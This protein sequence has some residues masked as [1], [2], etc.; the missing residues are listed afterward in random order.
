MPLATFAVGLTVALLVIAKASRDALFLSTYDVKQ[1]P[2]L[3]AVAAGLSLAA[4]LFAGR[5]FV[6]RSPARVLPGLFVLNALVHAVEVALIPSMPAVASVL[7]FLHLA[8]FG[9]TTMAG[10]WAVVN[11]SFDPHRAKRAVAQIALGGPVGGVAGGVLGLGLAQLGGVRI[12]LSLLVLLSMFAALT[13]HRLG[14]L[15]PT[16]S[17]R[18]PKPKR[19]DSPS[20]PYLRDLGALVFLI[21]VA[22]A[23]A[24]YWVS[25][26]AVE[27]YTT[28]SSLMSFFA[29]LHMAVGVLAFLMQATF[30]RLSL[31]KLGIAGTTALLPGAAL[32]LSASPLV[33][34]ALWAVVSLRATMGT[35]AASLYRAG[36]ELLYT[37]LPIQQKRVAKMLVDVGLDRV[38]TAA[39]AGVVTLL[40]MWAPGDAGLAVVLGVTS[41]LTLLLCAK[42]HAGY[43]HALAASLRSGSVSLEQSDVFDSAT[44]RTLAETQGLDRNQILEEIEKMRAG[45]PSTPPPAEAP[46]IPPMELA[47][48][49]QLVGL[50]RGVELLRTSAGR[51]DPVLEAVSVLRSGSAA[52][53]R[54]QMGRPIEPEWAPFVIALLGRRDVA[55][56]AVGAL[57]RE[58]PRYVGQLVDTLL[59]ETQPEV[60]RRRIPRVLERCSD[61][62]AVNGLVAALADPSVQV[63]TQ[64]GLALLE[65]TRRFSEVQLKADAVMAA[66]RLELERA[67]DAEQRGTL[68]ADPATWDEAARSRV[69]QGVEFC[70]I[71][72]SLVL[73][74]EP[75]QLA[76]KALQ[77]QDASLR[78]TALEYFE[79]VLPEDIRE[80]GTGFLRAVSPRRPKRATPELVA[81]LLR[82]RSA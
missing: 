27:T 10:V 67:H 24:D 4:A 17:L 79:T 66:V 30:A 64:S 77:G 34:P 56:A 47:F 82:S 75:L 55:H 35:L 25:A 28:D 52:A 39:G 19:G 61:Q 50:P 63:R 15:A 2:N 51:E 14:T 73:E 44:R 58:L 36:Y 3:M 32:L 5:L 1:L 72:L 18:A 7:L 54:A 74:R 46:S 26:R 23:I 62:R 22:A 13:T 57:R 60:V 68:G 69:Q 76:Y 80:Q 71:A 21:S 31:H 16:A 12:G 8:A 45:Q 33:L 53:M 42:L 38:G 48:D 81:E 29:L 49:D 20:G 78:G 65:L 70:M 11:E 40:L 9:A 6:T 37:P 41:A 59:D 43:I